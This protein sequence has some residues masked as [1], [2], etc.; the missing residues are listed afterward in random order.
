MTPTQE[1]IYWEVKREY[2]EEAANRFR[3]FLV[4]FGLY[5][6]ERDHSDVPF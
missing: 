2:G 5:R 6:Y 3:E 4:F 1:W